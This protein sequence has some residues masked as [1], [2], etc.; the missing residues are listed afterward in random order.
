ML[1]NAAC[2]VGFFQNSSYALNVAGPLGALFAFFAVGLVVLC[3]MQCIGEMII[4]FPTANAMV[5]FVNKFVDEDLAVIVGIGYWFMHCA[6]SASLIISS[7]NLI[8]YWNLSITGRAILST[9]IPILFFAVNS[10]RVRL[11]GT[12]QLTLGILKVLL[13]STVIV[14]MFIASVRRKGPSPFLDGFQHN[15]DAA[16]SDSAAIFIAISLAVFP[17]V[18]IETITTMSF[19]TYRPSKDLAMAVKHIPWIL[20]LF[21]IAMSIFCSFSVPSDSVQLSSYTNQVMG[22]LVPYPRPNGTTIVNVSAPI[23]A[24]RITGLDENFINA[25]FVFCALTSANMGLYSASRSLFGMARTLDT[26]GQ[27]PLY[28]IIAG[29]GLVEPRTQVPVRAVVASV[30]VFCWVPLIL[31]SVGETT[32]LVTQEL[33]NIA[34]VNCILVWSSQCI[35]YI[36]YHHFQRKYHDEL[37]GKLERFRAETSSMLLT[38]FQPMTAWLGLL[39]CIMLIFVFNGACLWNGQ[40][41]DIKVPGAFLSPFLAIVSW[42]AVKSYRAYKD[43]SVSFFVNIHSFTTFE[44][45]LLFLNDT[46][47]PSD[48]P[49]RLES[50]Q[51]QDDTSGAVRGPVI[52]N[53]ASLTTDIDLESVRDPTLKGN[54]PPEFTFATSPALHSTRASRTCPIISEDVTTL[55]YTRVGSSAEWSFEPVLHEQN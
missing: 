40:D 38:K 47:V 29:F 43:E 41:L 20:A 7:M 49:T 46:I 1:L 45:K 15:K 4:T 55:P 12:L 35:A 22:G 39:G 23:I 42:I 48:Y 5:E 17:F 36:R 50:T 28:S 16:G 51:R 33:V 52:R 30:L 3:V 54:N 19:E 53:A 8:G 9:L 37:Q 25:V 11:F 10:T 31:V 18:G 2:G 27:F 21:Y 6:I 32:L 24:T 13:V 26:D 34:V 44:Q 14:F